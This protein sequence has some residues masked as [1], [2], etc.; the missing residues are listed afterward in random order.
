MTRFNRYDMHRNMAIFLI[1]A[2]MLPLLSAWFFQN[3]W[4]MVPCGLCLLERW[5]YRI[6]L[7][8]G[9][10]ALF[11]SDR[12]VSWILGLGLLIFLVSMGLAF[13][14]I[15]VEQGWWSS[16]LPECNSVAVHQG[17]LA[18]RFSSLPDRPNKPCDLPSYVFSWLPLSLTTLNGL[19]SFGIFCV[20]GWQFSSKNYSRRIYF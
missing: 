11:I 19:Y 18:D 14:H 12:L 16:P 3:I 17:D 4:H 5:P 2:G 1:L 20:I 15:G 9:V 7:V 10:V 6:V 8:I 13:L